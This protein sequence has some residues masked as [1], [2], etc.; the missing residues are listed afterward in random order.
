[1]NELSQRFRQAVDFL[2]KN[3]YAKNDIAVARRLG[4]AKSTFSMIASGRRPPTWETILEFCDAYPIDLKWI[5]TGA[6]NMVKEDREIALLRRIEELERLL[7][8]LRE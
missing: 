8:E 1:M 3:G 4:M 5:R 6:G 7:K 2:K